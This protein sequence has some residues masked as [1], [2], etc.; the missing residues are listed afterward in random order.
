MQRNVDLEQFWA[1]NDDTG[2]IA[3]VRREIDEARPTRGLIINTADP[4]NDGSLLNSMRTV[5]W[6]IQPYGRVRQTENGPAA[7]R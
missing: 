4:I 3:E 7:Q 1:D 5:M 2:I 6:T